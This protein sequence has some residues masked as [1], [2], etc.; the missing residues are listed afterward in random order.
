M[1]KP[2]IQGMPPFER[3]WNTSNEMMHEGLYISVMKNGL[4]GHSVRRKLQFKDQVLIDRYW[5]ICISRSMETLEQLPFGFRQHPL[6]PS[7]STFHAAQPDFITEDCFQ[8]SLIASSSWGV[9]RFTIFQP[10]LLGPLLGLLSD[11]SA[12]YHLSHHATHPIEE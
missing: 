10:T 5:V 2:K 9:S 1:A 4:P 12:S 11:H 7:L 6:D 8:I 3:L